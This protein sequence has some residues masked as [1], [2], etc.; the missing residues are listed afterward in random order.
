MAAG[1]LALSPALAADQHVTVHANQVVCRIQPTT[2][3]ANMEDLHYQMVGG[4]DSQLLHGESF[5]EHAPTELAPHKG[6]ISGFAN[7]RGT[8]TA[9]DDVLTVQVQPDDGTAWIEGGLDGGRPPATR[10]EG[11]T[12]DP[13]TR[14]TSLAPAPANVIA[15]QAEFRFP[16]H[17]AAAAGLIS[18]V[19]P[20][21]ADNGWNWYAGYTVDLNPTGGTVRLLA[22]Q[23][24]NQHAELASVR[25]ALPL[26]EW[27]PVALHSEGDQLIVR[28]AGRDVITHQ[29]ARPLALGHFGFVS[30]GAAGFRNLDLVETGHESAVARRAKEDAPSLRV[31]N[32]VALAPNPLL[33]QPGDALSLRWS[34]VHTGTAQGAFTFDPDGW[35]P[36][37]RSQRLEYRGGTGEFG[38]A[39]AGLAGRG[40]TFQAG[41]PYEG[42]LRVRATK[43]TEVVASLRASDGAVLAEHALQVA[44]GPAFQRLEFTLVPHSNAWNGR[45]AI[46]LRSP[47][48]VTLGYAFLQPGEWNRYKGLPIRRDLAQALL[49]QGIQLLRLNGGMIEVPGYRWKTL[50]GPRDRRPPYNGFYDRYCS[51]GFGPVEHLAFC[52]AAGLVGVVG[53]NKDESPADVADFVAYCNAAAGTPAGD[54]RAADGHPEPLGLRYYQ[55]GNES[56]VN[57]AYV[58]HF[59]RVAEAV[60]AVDP[61]ITL[62]PCG[63]TYGAKAN[64]DPELMRKKYA[65]HLDL[66]RFVKA[67]GHRLIWDVHAFN[68]RDDPAESYAGHLPG[69]IEFSRWLTRLEP[70][71]GPVPI[72]VGEFNAGRFN[73]NRGLAH[74]V[75]LAQTHRAGE[76]VWGG[77]LPNVSQPWDI[78]QADWKAVLWTQGNLYY[79]GDRVWPQ[80]AYF[81][82]QMIAQAWAPEVVRVE[83]TAAPRTLDVL[84]A[85]NADGRTLV[86]RIVN[87][88]PQPQT[89]ALDLRA[90]RPAARPARLTT[91]ACDD[92]MAFN[93]LATP[94]RIRP[95]RSDWTPAA[96]RPTLTLPA[97]S[98]TVLE[99]ES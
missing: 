23:R 88:L 98:F 64:D 92:P 89:I 21:H 11:S 33:T 82:Q 1:A 44:G 48:A 49:D 77:A 24:A 2:L 5:F 81:V 58:E 84:A 60:W 83:H 30:R 16:T 54:R 85:R 65:A 41:Q 42:F 75:E 74:A 35:H 80:T 99:I 46:T 36:G 78:Y 97:S 93:T 69:G 73:F 29:P 17:G 68:K 56:G 22:A 39:N 19:H 40:I 72:L 9:R 12:K 50:H 62:L 34:R 47:A 27:I 70:E 51:S 4:F 37:L 52:R 55:V 87:L 6:Q 15:I 90:F 86:L 20:N 32:Q 71:L 66:T 79:T 7:V 95:V 26:G 59:K 28:V 25:V 91:L 14:L 76:V 38:C 13:G 53:L 96:D 8:W 94:D 67:R 57:A 10:L 31:T 63:L 61:E 18:H 3:G 45:F 43:P